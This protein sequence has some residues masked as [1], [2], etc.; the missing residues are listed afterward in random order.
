MGLSLQKGAQGEAFVS[1]IK[2]NS[3][4]D[5]GYVP[6]GDGALVISIDDTVPVEVFVF[7]VSRQYLSKLLDG[8]IRDLSLVLE[9]PLGYIPP[10]G[11]HGL[12]FDIQPGIS[13]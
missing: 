11:E 7:D 10:S 8:R 6:V 12:A 9:E 5:G 1:H 3:I 4:E 2:T 13:L